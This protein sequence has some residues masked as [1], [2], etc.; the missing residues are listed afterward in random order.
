MGLTRLS[1]KLVLRFASFWSRLFT[2]PSPYY[3]HFRPQVFLFLKSAPVFSCSHLENTG[4]FA[5]HGSSLFPLPAVFTLKH[6][7]LLTFL[8]TGFTESAFRF[9]LFLRLFLNWF[10]VPIKFLTGFTVLGSSQSLF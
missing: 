6:P 3:F 1:A 8:F 9:S 7:T 2:I 4:D 10:L 5:F